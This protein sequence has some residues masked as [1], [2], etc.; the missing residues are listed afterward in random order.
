MDTIRYV[1]ALVIWAT[2]PPA[3]LYWYLIHPFAGYWRRV[4]PARTYLVV[5]PITVLLMGMLVRWRA[6]VAGTD[7]GENWALFYTGLGLWGTAIFMER[8]I[9]KHLDFRTLA[10]VPE[11]RPLREGGREP[12]APTAA[13]APSDAPPET[14]AQGPGE[15][16]HGEPTLLT[17][18]MYAR[19][20]HP[21][22]VSVFVATVG[23]SLMANHG[24]AYAV[25]A[26][27]IPLILVLVH[28][29]ER[30]L[31]ERFGDAY[32]AYQA[33]VPALLP[34]IRGRGNSQA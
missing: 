31:V 9:R 2:I 8:R 19:M 7:L 18:G 17:E 20:R 1:L 34:R 33:R 28:L 5:V 14:G 23:W 16:R 3:F 12:G 29:E 22:Y 27:L 32:R 13:P 10:G 11:L 24:A 25:T 15:D 26:A 21:R 30:E 4:G 6:P